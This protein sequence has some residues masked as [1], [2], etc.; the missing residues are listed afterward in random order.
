LAELSWEVPRTSSVKRSFIK[1]IG[2]FS[3]DEAAEILLL[4]E[5]RFRTYETM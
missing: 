5:N 2:V 1:F 4:L 3:K